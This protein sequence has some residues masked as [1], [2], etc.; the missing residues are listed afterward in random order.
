MTLEA[1]TPL[2]RAKQQGW[3]IEPCPVCHKRFRIR[4]HPQNVV[5]VC[6]TCR[7]HLPDPFAAPRG[8]DAPQDAPPSEIAIE[9][10]NAA[11]PFEVP[12]TTLPF[13]LLPVIKWREA[14]GGKLRVKLERILRDSQPGA[15]VDWERLDAI[16]TLNPSH[17]YVG[18][19]EWPGY[20]LYTFHGTDRCLL[21]CPIFGNAIYVLKGDWTELV[22]LSKQ[23][24]R[25]D[26]KRRLIRVVHTD[27]WLNRVRKALR[28]R[29]AEAAV[30]R[31]DPP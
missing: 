1:T 25:K 23:E 17:R 10:V 29:R 13:E 2:A 12:E 3:A 21:E 18:R 27:G 9:P 22:R 20:V 26:Y 15:E 30:R 8:A 19:G 5:P 31:I 24:L 14:A 28:L 6:S 16:E 11:V 7:V 4:P